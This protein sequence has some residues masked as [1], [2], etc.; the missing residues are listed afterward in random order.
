MH[1]VFL[2]L[3]LAF[4]FFVMNLLCHSKYYHHRHLYSSMHLIY[5]TIIMRS[6]SFL[7]CCVRSP[8]ECFFGLRDATIA[9]EG[10]QSLDLCSVPSGNR[11]RVLYYVSLTV[12]RGIGFAI[13]PSIEPPQL[14]RLSRQT[15]SLKGLL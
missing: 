7:V 11:H 10:M 15:R 9:G 3:L 1:I 12:I 6:D 2:W 8:Q 4:N 5:L 14:T 13:S